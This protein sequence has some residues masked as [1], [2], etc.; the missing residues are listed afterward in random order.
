MTTDDLWPMTLSFYWNT[1]PFSEL[2][3]LPYFEL[4]YWHTLVDAGILALF[5]HPFNG[6]LQLLAPLLPE[7]ITL[8]ARMTNFTPCKVKPISRKTCDIVIMGSHTTN[9]RHLFRQ[10][11]FATVDSR[12]SPGKKKASVLK[13]DQGPQIGTRIRLLWP[14]PQRQSAP[15]VGPE[16]QHSRCLESVVPRAL[17]KKMYETWL[18]ANINMFSSNVQ[19]SEFW[20]VCIYLYMYMILYNC[21]YL[22]H[23]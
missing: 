23:L 16:G 7:S 10:A 12:R 21:V 17:A 20:N 8:L 14:Q 22:I 18:Y 15:L 2:V 3:G 5:S 9:C 13:L 19:Y 11:S 4:R 1:S 6:E